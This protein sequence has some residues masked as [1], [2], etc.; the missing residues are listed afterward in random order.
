MSRPTPK[1]EVGG[2]GWEGVS[3]PTPRGEVGGSGQGGCPGPYPGGSRPTPGGRGWVS[4]PTP[5]GRGQAQACGGVSQH[6][7][8]QTPPTPSIRLLLRAFLLEC[9]LVNFNYS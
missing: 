1:V 7:L 3:R 8:R 9:I 4:R 6:A 5:S 2:S